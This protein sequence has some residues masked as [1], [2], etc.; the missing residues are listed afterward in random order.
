VLKIS[1]SRTNCEAPVFRG[2]CVP[3][4]S[5]SARNATTP[6]VRRSDLNALALLALADEF[7][8]RARE[9]V[10]KSMRFAH[11]GVTTMRTMPS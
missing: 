7:L 5:K 3:D 8:D 2:T 9:V 4:P 6:Q 10:T 1:S 11:V